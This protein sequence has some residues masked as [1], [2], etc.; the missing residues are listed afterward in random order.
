MA[1]KYVI[2][3]SDSG[4]DSYKP[5]GEHESG[6][7]ESAITAFLNTEV[8]GVANGEKFGE[9]DYRAVAKSSWAEKPREI[10]RKISYG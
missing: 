6:G 8:S 3:R 1:T 4:Y 7:S 9:G 5:I 2:L 10:R